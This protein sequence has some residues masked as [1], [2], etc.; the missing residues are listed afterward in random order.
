MVELLFIPFLLSWC[1]VTLFLWGGG[2]VVGGLRRALIESTCFTWIRFRFGHF[3]LCPQGDSRETWTQHA[4]NTALG[5]RTCF[6][7]CVCV[8]ARA[9]VR[10][11]VCGY[12]C[13]HA[14]L[15]SVISVVI[16]ALPNQ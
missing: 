11:S 12:V 4:E 15:F 8:C 14:I 1:S 5:G 2:F 6:S 16:V 3:H 10:A 7:V 9:Y 13:M